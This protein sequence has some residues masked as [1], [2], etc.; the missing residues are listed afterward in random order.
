MRVSI[1]AIKASKSLV[2]LAAACRGLS[3]TL[4]KDVNFISQEAARELTFHL[5]YETPVDTSQAL[6]NWLVSLAFP[7]TNKINAHK[8]GA[9]GSTKEYSAARAYMAAQRIIKQK[10]PRIDLIVTNNLSYLY[11]LNAGGSKQQPTAFYI[12]RIIKRVDDA[13]QKRLRA[14]LNGN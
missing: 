14:Y 6:S 13:A 8:E 9:G 5:I 4:E 10:K 12:Q 1:K 2:E 7:T 3:A 11:K